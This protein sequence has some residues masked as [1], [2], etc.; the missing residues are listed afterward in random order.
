MA[1][2]YAGILLFIVCVG[3]AVSSC[4]SF[5]DVARN[6]FPEDCNE[7]QE[8]LADSGAAREDGLYKLF[9]DGKENSPWIAYCR[10]MRWENPEEYIIVNPATNWS[11][12]NITG[13]NKIVTTFSKLRFDPHTFTVDARDD[14]GATT[15]NWQDIGFFDTSRRHLPAGFAAY[16]AAGDIVT[17]SIDLRGSGFSFD[18]RVLEAPSTFL[19]APDGTKYSVDSDGARITMSAHDPIGSHVFAGKDCSAQDP[20]RAD[21]H[22]LWPVKYTGN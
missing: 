9:L 13:N 7:V 11:S 1:F 17:A 20:R 15:S 10:G 2:R 8:N 4:E 5:P 3:I 14:F 18:D 12:A 22:V 6:T 19:C 21:A 16:A